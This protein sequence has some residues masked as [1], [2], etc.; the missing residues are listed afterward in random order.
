M[1]RLRSHCKSLDDFSFL[2]SDA[3]SPTRIHK[4]NTDFARLASTLPLR[5]ADGAL[6]VGLALLALQA[7][8]PYI[9]VEPCLSFSEFASL[10]E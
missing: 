6:I 4:K 10:A 8:C 5:Q 9:V 1:E 3:F 2:E 7:R